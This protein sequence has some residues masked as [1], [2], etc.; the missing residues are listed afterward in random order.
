MYPSIFLYCL[1]FAVKKKKK[2][3]DGNLFPYEKKKKN[4]VVD[5]ENGKRIE[6]CDFRG[7]FFCSL[8]LSCNVL[9]YNPL[10]F[11]LHRISKDDEEDEEDEDDREK[12]RTLFS[13]LCSSTFHL[14][15]F[16]R[17]F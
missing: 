5:P 16:L 2:K 13:F 3:D 14:L 9:C 10:G 17:F 8:S 11:S 1:V 15:C 7:T 12:R 6:I 4:E